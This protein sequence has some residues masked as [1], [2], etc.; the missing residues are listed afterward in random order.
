MYLLFTV[1]IKIG[2]LGTRLKLPWMFWLDWKY[3]QLQYLVQQPA[4]QNPRSAKS[5]ESV[6]VVLFDDCTIAHSFTF[7]SILHYWNDTTVA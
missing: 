1:E 5:F 3:I 7:V 6:R 4:Q 2:L